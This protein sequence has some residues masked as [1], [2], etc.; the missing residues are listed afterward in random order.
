MTEDGPDS[1][2]FL[3]QQELEPPCNPFPFQQRCPENALINMNVNLVVSPSGAYNSE[4]VDNAR[5]LHN[6]LLWDVR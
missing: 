6:K 5:K 1:I 3:S 2:S 4:K